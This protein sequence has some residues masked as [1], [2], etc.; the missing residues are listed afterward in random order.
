LLCAVASE[1]ADAFREICMQNGISVEPFG[2]M[3]AADGKKL[4][5]VE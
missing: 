4:V 1:Q 2:A 3:A 5:R